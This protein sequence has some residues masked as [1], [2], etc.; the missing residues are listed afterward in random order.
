MP[1]TGAQPGA[2]QHDGAYPGSARSSGPS[3]QDLLDTDT[4]PVPVALRDHSYSYRGSADLPKSRYTSPEFAALEAEYL[5]R[6]T[7]QPACRE[8]EITKSGDHVVYDVANE[9]LIVTRQADGSIRAFH[10]ACLHRGTRLRDTDGRVG[11]FRCPFHGWT[12]GVDGQLTDLPCEWDFPHITQSPETSCLPEA[13]V[14]RWCGWVFVNMDPNCEPFE[15]YAAKLI[16]H[17]GTSFDFAN[18]YVTFHAVKEVACN[19]K[20]CMEAFSEGYHVIATH[21]Q[22]LEFTGDANSEYSVWDDSPYVSRFV[23]GFG[24]QSPHL[25]DTLSPQQ[26]VDAYLEF[27]ARMPRGSGL[28]VNDDANPRALVAAILRTG[29]SARLNTDLDALSDSEVLDAILYHLFPAF[30]PWAG[31]GQPLVYRW[32]PGR[33][34]DTCFMDVWRL[35]PVPDSGEA[36]APAVCTRLTLDQSWKEAP[37]MGGLADVFEQD[38]EN[39]PMVQAGL[40]STGKRG[41]SF[42]NYQEARLRQIHQMIDQFILRGLAREGRNASEVE[43]YLVPEG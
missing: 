18:R 22:I 43:R 32:R 30:A 5:W 38:M 21:P 13:R 37:R 29:M 17:F 10:N 6:Y 3:I 1:N 24:V 12:W 11:S 7:W 41:V 25:S 33:T 34:P 23:N 14:A 9:S 36:P 28:T 31:L 8:D 4:R 16:E 39:L 27:A 26:V 15:T 35:A 40:K 2:G 19:W 20:V 42:G